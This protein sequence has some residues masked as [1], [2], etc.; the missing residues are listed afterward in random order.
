MSVLPT[1]RMVLLLALGLAF[2]VLLL[3]DAAYFWPAVAFDGVIL[4][5]F[6]FDA[7][8]AARAR[9][10]EAQRLKPS[11]LS[12]GEANEITLQLDNPR[13]RTERFLVRD[14][15]PTEF[16]AD[17][18]Y[19]DVLLPA[20]GRARVSYRLLTTDRGN[21]SFGDIHVRRQGPL[22]LAQ[23]DQTVPAAEAVPVYP[24]LLDVRRYEAL[25]RTRFQPDEGYR[26][27][28]IGAG[29]EFDH[30][31]DYTVDDD[32]RFV[33]W[34]ASARRAKLTTSV[35][36]VEHSQDV[37]FCLDM[38]RMMA[39]H[40]GNLTKL[41]HAINAI[42]MLAHVSQRFQ[43]N[44]GLLTFTHTVH[45]YLRPSKG[46]AQFAKFL[47]ALYSVKPEPCYVNYREAFQYLVQ[48][49]T[50]RSLI[51][52]F[53]D[54]LDAT[55]SAEFRD[56]VRLLKRFHLPLTIAVADVPLQALAV[57]SPDTREELYAT[58]VAR[59]LLRQRRELLRSLEREGV[60]ILDTVPERLTNEAVNRYLMLKKGMRW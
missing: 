43:D 39:A 57:Q 17:Q 49:H 30:F 13:G 34:K 45:Q 55:V 22:G 59:D 47:D 4:A 23:V 52:I 54:L 1:W 56:A 25:M 35:F 10:P 44:L 46:H 27:R 12:L 7:F 42:M 5:L 21:F 58:A 33:N 32:Y 20:H 9:P 51:M 41:D 15:P 19:H 36:E 50:K 3:W 40:V 11:K 31:R 38:G 37:I 8:A 26:A 18:I 29:R 2:P 16:T 60:L 24:N 14:T 53:T 6:V 48:R 28:R